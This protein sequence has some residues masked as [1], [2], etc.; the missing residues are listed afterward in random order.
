METENEVIEIGPVTYITSLPEIRI[1]VDAGTG[2]S[3]WQHV[4]NQGS[5]CRKPQWR[6]YGRVYPRNVGPDGLRQWRRPG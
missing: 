6:W 5:L 2:R 4:S 3:N 1:S